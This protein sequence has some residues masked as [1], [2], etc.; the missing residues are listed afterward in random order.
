MSTDIDGNGCICVEPA[1]CRSR[2]NRSWHRRS[3]SCAVCDWRSCI[4]VGGSECSGLAAALNRAGC[5]PHSTCSGMQS[6][7]CRSAMQAAL[8][9]ANG[10]GCCPHSTCSD[11][12]SLGCRSAMQA[13]L[14]AALNRAGCWLHLRRACVVPQPRQSVLAPKELLVCCV[15]LAQWHL[16]SSKRCS[17]MQRS[18]SSF[19]AGRS[20][21]ASTDSDVS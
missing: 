5:C 14:A 4:C 18:G 8:R 13:R 3:C 7:G 19:D 11:M 17:Q 16:L 2:A 20:G 9:T 1:L 15:R 21:I 12:Q 6:L 10:V